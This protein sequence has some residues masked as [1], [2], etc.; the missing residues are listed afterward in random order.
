MKRP[1]EVKTCHVVLL[2]SLTPVRKELRRTRF[3]KLR[4]TIILFHMYEFGLLRLQMCKALISIR[5]ILQEQ[6]KEPI[7]RQ[8]R[9]LEDFHEFKCTYEIKS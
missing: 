7:V 1:D 3:Y 4:S 8:W 5:E 2:L 9:T 6:D